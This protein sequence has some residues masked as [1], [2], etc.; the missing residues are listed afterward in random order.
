MI[1]RIVLLLLFIVSLNSC[2]F[3]HVAME[4]VR[5]PVYTIGTS[6]NDFRPSTSA[7]T[8][9]VAF[10]YYVNNKRYLVSHSKWQ[11]LV[12]G[13]KFRVAYDSLDPSTAKVLIQEPLFL[14]DEER[15]KTTGTI[16]DLSTLDCFF[17][18]DAM[19][20]HYKKFQ[21]YYK[22]IIEKY[23]ELKIGSKCE[24]EYDPYIPHRVIIYLDR[25]IKNEN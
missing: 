8:T 17:E 22:G 24:V 12:T 1:K 7:G 3:W 19:G 20:I 23:P 11:Y 2:N 25:P 14:P 16:T 18:Y 9:E 13:E 21:H 6:V 10:E 5:V 4:T 15:I